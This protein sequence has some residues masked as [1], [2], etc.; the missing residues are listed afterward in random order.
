[1]NW[2]I[3][4]L[5]YPL[6]P[7]SSVTKGAS[8]TALFT[9]YFNIRLGLVCLFVL[10]GCSC[11]PV[12]RTVLQFWLLFLTYHLLKLA[13]SS[14]HKNLVVKCRRKMYLLLKLTSG[15]MSLSSTA[16]DIFYSL[17]PPACAVS[18]FH[19]H[20]NHFSRA[21]SDS[22]CNKVQLDQHYF[23]FMKLCL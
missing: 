20:F 16:H 9:C 21:V 23:F 11:L 1:M 5:T 14:T 10:V 13:F 2:P 22:C 18:P 12:L 15:I 7:V 8:Q 3:S 6:F 4:S 19:L 17:L